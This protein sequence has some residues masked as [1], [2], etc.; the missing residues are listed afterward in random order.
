MPAGGKLARA[1]IGSSG[2]APEDHA[3]R[4]RPTANRRCWRLRAERGLRAAQLGQN[5]P[6][7]EVKESLLIRSYL[8]DVYVCVSGIHEL[9]DCSQVSLGVGAVDHAPGDVVGSGEAGRLLEV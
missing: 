3:S 8:V 2:A 7:I 5:V 9:A 1:S 6:A 4:P